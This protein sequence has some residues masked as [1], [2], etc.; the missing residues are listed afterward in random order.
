MI[1]RE[2]SGDLEPRTLLEHGRGGCADAA[3]GAGRCLG[4]LPAANPESQ[5]QAAVWAV[6]L[7]K[8]LK[9]RAAESARHMAVLVKRR[10]YAEHLISR[11][12]VQNLHESGLR[13]S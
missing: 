3:P 2:R 9:V 5:V 7:R 11:S 8:H 6:L 10:Q 12:G 13:R 4:C 1:A